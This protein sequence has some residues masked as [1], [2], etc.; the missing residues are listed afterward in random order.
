MEEQ[1]NEKKST[2]QSGHDGNTQVRNQRIYL[3]ATAHEKAEL[4]RLAGE[5]GFDSLAPFVRQRA[6]Y[7]TDGPYERSGEH[8]AW[9]GTVNRIANYID[10]IAKHLEQGKKPD[11]D[12]LL[13][14]MQISDMAEETLK[15]VRIY[16]E[17]AIAES[18]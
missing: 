13:L 5:A 15:E 17:R 14:V 7:G 6:L 18:A 16:N 8:L 3:R 1:T 11:E 2:G 9:L 10:E 12:L 4:R